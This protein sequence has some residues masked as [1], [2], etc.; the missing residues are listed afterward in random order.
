MFWRNSIAR[1]DEKRVYVK[2][3]EPKSIGNLSLDEL[4]I[5]EAIMQHRSL[6]PNELRM[7]LRNSSKSSKLS[8]EYLMEKGFV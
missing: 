6:S 2:I 7:V 8:L 3:Y 1:V 5:L 4:F